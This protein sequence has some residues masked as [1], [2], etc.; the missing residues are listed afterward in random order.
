MAKL[1]TMELL[2]GAPKR[3][4]SVFDV[5]TE[6]GAAFVRIGSRIFYRRADLDACLERCRVEVAS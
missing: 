1:K 3:A 2:D 4:L 5:A 6:L